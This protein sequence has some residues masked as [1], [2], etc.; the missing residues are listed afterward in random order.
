MRVRFFCLAGE[1]RAN[2][3]LQNAFLDESPTQKEAKIHPFKVRAYFWIG[4]RT[5]FGQN[6][7]GSK[8]KSGWRALV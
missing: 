3:E 4:I 7:T 8:I 1:Q 2:Q 6:L 5:Y